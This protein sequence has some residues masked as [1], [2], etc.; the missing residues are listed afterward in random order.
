MIRDLFLLFRLLSLQSWLRV[1]QP[2]QVSQFFVYL[3]LWTYLR[4]SDCPRSPGHCWVF[5]AFLW[6]KVKKAAVLAMIEVESWKSLS[7][8]RCHKRRR[9]RGRRLLVSDNMSS[10]DLSEIS[11]SYTELTRIKGVF[12]SRGK[13]LCFRGANNFHKAPLSFDMEFPTKWIIYIDTR[14]RLEKK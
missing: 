14:Q 10:T 3:H 12:H 13:N 4:I 7:D 1:V 11:I 2:S 8:V 9:W 5:S 6:L